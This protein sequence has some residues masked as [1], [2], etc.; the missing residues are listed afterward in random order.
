MEKK[1][2][3]ERLEKEITSLDKQT[4]LLSKVFLFWSGIGAGLIGY[5]STIENLITK[6]LMLIALLLAVYKIGLMLY[7]FKT[8][9]DK[10][11]YKNGILN[12]LNEDIENE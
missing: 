11:K 12:K 9:Y 3:I 5:I 6:I 7:E 4:N 8:I 10:I 2:K 1:D